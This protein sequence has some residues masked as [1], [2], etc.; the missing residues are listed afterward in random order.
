[1]DK[2]DA[3]EA[4]APNK[5]DPANSVDQHSNQWI[6]SQAKTFVTGLDSFAKATLIDL[7]LHDFRSDKI[8]ADNDE[9]SAQL[10]HRLLHQKDMYAKASGMGMG[11]IIDE[12]ITA[13]LKSTIENNDNNLYDKIIFDHLLGP[14]HLDSVRGYLEKAG[15]GYAGPSQEEEQQMPPEMGGGQPD[16]GAAPMQGAPPPAMAEGTS[17]EAGAAPDDQMQ[18]IGG[19]ISQYASQA[20]ID[21][22]AIQQMVQGG[23][24]AG[25]AKAVLDALKQANPQLADQ[26]LQDLDSAVNGQSTPEAGGG[27]APAAAPQSSMMMGKAINPNE[28]AAVYKEARK[29]QFTKSRVIPT[30]VP[31]SV[32]NQPVSGADLAIAKFVGQFN[33]N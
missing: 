9:S 27:E 4:T 16:M 22:G 12:E 29:E 3:P 26:M 14:D 28:V 8:Y 10:I 15:Y 2:Y 33:I 25:A 30:N 11:R 20:G 6:M 1:L 17:P 23:D 7:I 21:P 31:L 32:N 24:L 13:I 18:A 5:Y 19:I